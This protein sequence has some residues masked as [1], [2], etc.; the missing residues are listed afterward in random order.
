MPRCLS[1]DGSRSRAAFWLPGSGH[2][3]QGEARRSRVLIACKRLLGEV[4][5]K[6]VRWGEAHQSARTHRLGRVFL[7]YASQEA[8]AAQ[9]ICDALRAAGIEVWFD[10]SELRGG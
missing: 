2:G 3:G 1:S 4:R 7:S 9:S 10:K 5:R 8:E 6:R